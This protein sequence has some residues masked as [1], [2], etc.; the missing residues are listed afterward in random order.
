MIRN[1]TD[2][3]LAPSSRAASNI[4][5]SME[6]KAAVSSTM[7][8]PMFFQM[9]RRYTGRGVDVSV[10]T[11][12][13]MSAAEAVGITIGR[14]NANRVFRTARIPNESPSEIAS[15]SSTSAGTQITI[16]SMEFLSAS[17]KYSFARVFA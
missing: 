14:I 5:P 9:N 13:Q 2:I 17:R 12:C 3:S 15:A 6:V 4:L 8:I 11:L 1:M 10:N 16:I 7:H